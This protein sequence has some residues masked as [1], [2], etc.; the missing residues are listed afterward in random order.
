[1]ARQNKITTTASHLLIDGPDGQVKIDLVDIGLILEAISFGMIK[2]SGII[3]DKVQY[4]DE[5]LE[6]A[7][8]M[9]DA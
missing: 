5:V 4:M 7:R 9:A 6:V 3:G 2:N 1:M 8:V